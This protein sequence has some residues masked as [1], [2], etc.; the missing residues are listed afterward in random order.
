[1]LVEQLFDLGHITLRH[2]HPRQA[3][4]QAAV[5]EL[6][7]PGLAVF[8]IAIEFGGIKVGTPGGALTQRAC[9]HVVQGAALQSEF[10]RT[11][12][13]CGG[14]IVL[15]H[16][17][18]RRCGGRSSAACGGLGGSGPG[19]HI[20]PRI[21]VQLALVDVGGHALGRHG[22]ELAIA[23][24]H[25]DGATQH[26]G[27]GAAQV[28][29]IG[30]RTE[31]PQVER[32][33]VPQRWGI[34]AVAVVVRQAH[35]RFARHLVVEAQG[36]AA[37]RSLAQR[38]RQGQGQALQAG[39]HLQLRHPASKRQGQCVRCAAGGPPRQLRQHA[40][41]RGLLQPLGRGGALGTDLHRR[42]GGRGIGRQRAHAAFQPHGPAQRLG[43]HIGQR[44]PGLAELHGAPH[45]GERRGVG[46]DAQFVTRQR[47]AALHLGFVD[48]ADG[49]AQPQLEV[50]VARAAGL[51]Q[52][53]AR[54]TA[55]RRG[56]HEREQL[57]QRAARIGTHADHGVR[58]VWNARLDFG[59]AQA[60]AARKAAAGAAHLHGRAFKNQL[61]AQIGQRRPGQGACGLQRGGHV[62]VGDVLDARRNAELALLGVIEGQVVQV[63]FDPELHIAGAASDHRIAHV[64]A[65]FG[66]NRQGQVAVHACAVSAVQRAGE[67]Q[68]PRKT[69]PVGRLGGVAGMPGGAGI[70]LGIGIG[71]LHIVG[72]HGDAAAVHL[73]AHV[74]T[75]PVERQDGLLKNPRQHQR[76]RRHGQRRLAPC[77]G[78]VDVHVGAPQAQ[79]GGGCAIRGTGQRQPLDAPLDL[80]LLQRIQRPL[81]GGLDL[82]HQPLGRVGAQGVVGGRS[83]RQTAGHLRQGRQVQPVGP[84]FALRRGLAVGIGV[85]QPQVAAGPGQAVVGLELQRLRREF[86]PAGEPTPPQPALDGRQNQRAQIGRQRGVHIGQRQVGRA[87]HHLPA[88]HIGPGPQ[89]APALRH[90]DAHIGVVPQVRH[91]DPREMGKHLAAPVLPVAI[92]GA[93]QRRAKQTDQTETVAP[94]RRRCGIHPKV[95]APVAVAQ[96]QVHL[97]QRQLGGA[98]LLVGPAHRAAL[99]IDLALREQPVG[100][101]AAV[102]LVLGK[103]QSRHIDAPVARAPHIQVRA[104]DVKLLEPPLQQRPGRQRHH[105]PRQAQRGTACRIQQRDVRQLN[106][107]DQPLG[108]GHDGADLHGNPQYPCGLRL[109]LWAE[110]TDSR[111]NP[112][113]KSPP[114]D[115]QQQPEREQQAQ[116]PPRKTCPNFQQA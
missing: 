16:G 72:L 68:H 48:V 104:F 28:A 35:Q 74:G 113:M 20:V 61:A 5:A 43:L 51:L 81:P 6:G 98:A 92:A 96:N 85:H 49:Q 115:G 109:Q 54:H 47:D 4:K 45:A 58:Q 29:H 32:D 87:A 10:P 116:R 7:R 103:F 23:Q 63:P 100:R 24:A 38:G 52:R 12:R 114:C 79:V 2:V 73:P 26:A 39:V 112:A 105:H 71:K 3:G 97:F 31:R 107:R 106:G 46:G 59:Q 37:V 19:E 110:I 91:I 90:L 42:L 25:T 27:L 21:H 75:E 84:Q 41:L 102:A 14:Q 77:L 53:I 108:A 95:V 57:G 44:K 9:H 30:G 66:G 70:A 69:R 86:K 78:H 17:L 60:L 80:V 22:G 99:D 62:G 18:P 36:Q 33:L 13:Q 50:G 67:V 101:R 94:F 93:Q 40:Q 111:H 83:E 34:A 65:G 56:G 89:R 64:V 55:Q 82:V 11:Q 88:A 15:R 76:P 1:M 8:Q